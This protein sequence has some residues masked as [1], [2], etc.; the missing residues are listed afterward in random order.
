MYI[1]RGCNRANINNKRADNGKR[2]DNKKSFSASEPSNILNYL[3]KEDNYNILR[4]KPY[5]IKL[6]VW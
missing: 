1:E 2:I 3:K 6:G 4:L 5:K